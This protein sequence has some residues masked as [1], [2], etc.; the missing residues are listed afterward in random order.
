VKTRTRQIDKDKWMVEEYII[1]GIWK[2]AHLK[3]FKTEGEA[4]SF[5]CYHSKSDV[6]HS[7]FEDGEKIK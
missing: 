6:V 4:D 7:Q 1:G 5:A 3:P 2:Y